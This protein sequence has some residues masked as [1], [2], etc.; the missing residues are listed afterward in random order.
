MGGVKVWHERGCQPQ[1]PELPDHDRAI[2][3]FV[4]LFIISVGSTLL[5]LLGPIGLLISLIA[6]CAAANCSSAISD[7]PRSNP[8]KEYKRT[9]KACGSVWHSLV[10]REQQIISANKTTAW[11]SMCG[12]PA[13]VAGGNIEISARKSELASL[14]KCPKCGS[15]NYNEEVIDYNNPPSI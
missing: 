7:N 13:G 4:T 12:G 14:H 15:A 5:S 2:P 1:L 10:A 11:T 9:C 6:P 8:M 3:F